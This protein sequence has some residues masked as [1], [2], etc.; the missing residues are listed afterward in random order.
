[1]KTAGLYRTNLENFFFIMNIIL[2]ARG[3]V[4]LYFPDLGSFSGLLLGFN[5]GEISRPPKILFR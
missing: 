2:P 4:P 3:S 5:A 1:M